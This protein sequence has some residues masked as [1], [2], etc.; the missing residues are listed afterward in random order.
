M[1]FLYQIFILL[2][3]IFDFILDKIWEPKPSVALFSQFYSFCFE[4]MTSNSH[5]S[6]TVKHLP[7]DEHLTNFGCKCQ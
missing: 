1:T 6:K 7:A 4:I 3:H 2:S 5:K